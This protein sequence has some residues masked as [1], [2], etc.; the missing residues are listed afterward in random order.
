MLLNFSDWTKLGDGHAPSFATGDVRLPGA[1]ALKDN[2]QFK[3]LLLYPLKP[4]LDL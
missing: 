2:K 1:L 4:D 3:A